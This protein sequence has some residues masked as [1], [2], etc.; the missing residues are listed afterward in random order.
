M[1][2]GSV[3]L[4]GLLFQNHGEFNCE[5]IGLV[6]VVHDHGPCCRID[7]IADIIESDRQRVDI[8]A[9]ERCDK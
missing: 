2:D 1:R 4:G 5:W 6:N 3:D 7:V 9:V 8:F